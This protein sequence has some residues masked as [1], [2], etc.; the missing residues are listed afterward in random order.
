MELLHQNFTL[1]TTAGTQTFG[2]EYLE[3]FRHYYI[4]ESIIF[5]VKIGTA[6]SIFIV[7]FLFSRNWRQPVFIFNQ[8]SLFLLIM[9]TIF[10]I[11]YTLGPISSMGTVLTLSTAGTTQNDRNISNASSIFQLLLIIS[12]ELSLF[13]QCW[14]MY[15]DDFRS[16]VKIVPWIMLVICVIPNVVFWFI[17]VV[18]NCI[19]L[20]DPVNSF[21]RR[22][23]WVYVV[24]RALFACSVVL[25]SLLSVLKLFVTLKRRKHMGLKQFGPFQIVFIMAAQTMIIPAI[26][27]LVD[28]LLPS[29][30]DTLSTLTAMFVTIFLPLS[31]IW[32]KF[33]STE[34]SVPISFNVSNFSPHSSGG[35]TSTYTT[36]TP[37]SPTEKTLSNFQPHDNLSRPISKS[38]YAPFTSKDDSDSDYHKIMVSMERNNNHTYRDIEK[39]QF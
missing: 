26:I 11:I 5:G 32:A 3:H 19:S 16:V 8:T 24:P 31:S 25:F 21:V 30:P 36:A 28:F 37:L 12:I 34:S 7:S 4:S 20:N 22:N 23:R 14:T 13:F 2:I 1:N 35:S 9:E 29:S 33:K 38:K 10:Y 18:A 15:R 39:N 17:Y 27:T 6:F